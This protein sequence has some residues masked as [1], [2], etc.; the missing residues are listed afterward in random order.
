[1]SKKKILRFSIVTIICG[2]IIYALISIFLFDYSDNDSNKKIEQK[3]SN[4]SN[5]DINVI[6]YN[7]YQEL[8]SEVYEDYSFVLLILNS[9]DS[10]S[11]KLLDEVIL[12]IKDKKYNL[13]VIYIDKLNDIEVSG[14]IDD[15]TNI[16]KYDKPTLVTPT[17]LFSKNGNIAYKHEGLIYS[18]ELI[19]KLK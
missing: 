17:L 7:K 1:M 4:E 11:K 5:K 13:Y 18:H 6:D 19:E 3:Q 10:I 8:R 16:M 2:L 15:I 14:I 12:S 9:E